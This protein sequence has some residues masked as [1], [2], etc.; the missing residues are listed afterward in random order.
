MY[1]FVLS[2]GV[3]IIK[4]LEWSLLIKKTETD[5]IQILMWFTII[6]WEIK[7]RGQMLHVRWML[8]LQ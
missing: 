2:T 5:W 3:C 8:G 7:R 6:I 4:R 1:L